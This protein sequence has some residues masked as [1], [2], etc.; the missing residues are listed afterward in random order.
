M[1][2][3]S[4]EGRYFHARPVN[5]QMV[6]PTVMVV[7]AGNC[8]RLVAPVAVEAE[9]NVEVKFDVPIYLVGKS[10][11]QA[12]PG[13]QDVHVNDGPEERDAFGVGNGWQDGELPVPCHCELLLRLQRA[14]DVAPAVRRGD[15]DLA[16]TCRRRTCAGEQGS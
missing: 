12:A 4:S 7:D 3:G 2:S 11:P 1:K 13:C 5:G 8:E 10:E 6:S 16:A 14:Q 9:V 15:G